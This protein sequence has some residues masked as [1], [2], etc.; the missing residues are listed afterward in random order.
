MNINAA[1]DAEQ[2]MNTTIL[3]H[4]GFQTLPKGLRQTLLFSETYFF[5]EAAPDHQAQK[6]VAE[7]AGRSAAEFMGIPLLPAGFHYRIQDEAAMLA[8][9][10]TSNVW[11]KRRS[12]DDDAAQT[13]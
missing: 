1:L 3:N 5:N 7:R 2:P 9:Y 4:P 13:V 12:R 11:D 8:A 6:V 10:L